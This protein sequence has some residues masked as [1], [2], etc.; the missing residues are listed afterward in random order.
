MSAA[1]EHQIGAGFAPEQVSWRPKG[2]EAVWLTLETVVWGVILGHVIHWTADAIYYIGTQTTLFTEAKHGE[3]VAV[4]GSYQ[5]GDW[6]DRLPVHLANLLHW[7]F[8]GFVNNG[9]A[10]PLW[11]ITWR[12]DIRYVFIGVLAGVVVTFL[13]SKPPKKRKDYTWYRIALTPVLAF[14][15]ALPGIAIGGI[16][17][18]QLHF[19]QTSGINPPASWGMLGDEIGQWSDS[20]KLALVVLGLLG[21]QLFAKYVSKGPADEIQ[22]LYAG[23]KANMILHERTGKLSA[24]GNFKDSIVIG[25]PGYRRRV[26][27]LVDSGTVTEVHST[28]IV[29]VLALGAFL[30]FV[31]AGYG[32]WLTLAGP[33]AGA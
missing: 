12:H 8:F 5:P 17:V 32:A 13:I 19:L 1:T 24:L 2:K 31:L 25:P 9:Q 27:Y 18:W 23:R 14:V 33:A 26:R 11:W 22:W 15:A 29:V 21:S 10:A 30:V 28:G 7:G 3:P 4:Y 20:G 6:W 16:A